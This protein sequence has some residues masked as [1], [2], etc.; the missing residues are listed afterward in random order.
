MEKKSIVREKPRRTAGQRRQ[1]QLLVFVLL[2]LLGVVAFSYYFFWP[3]EETFRLGVFTYAEVE[4]RDFYSW[5]LSQGTLLPRSEYRL[6]APFAGYVQDWQVGIGEMVGSGQVLAVLSSNQLQ[7]D[8]EEA[9][10]D[11]ETG[12]R[13]LKR[14]EMELN[15]EALQNNR[16]MARAKADLVEAQENLELQEELYE[17]E[18]I[19]RRELETARDQLE[20]AEFELEQ[21]HL[22][23][24]IKE[25]QNEARLN[26]VES[27]VVSL[28]EQI[29][30]LEDLLEQGEILAP[31]SGYLASIEVEG[32]RS[33]NQGTFLAKFIGDDGVFYKGEIDVQDSGLVEAGQFALL[34]G[35]T[36]DVPS[37][38]EYVSPLVGDD[39]NTVE[40]ILKP[41]KQD[42]L[43][44]NIKANA[45][46]RVGH[47]PGLLSLPR[48][49]YLVSGERLFVYVIDDDRAYQR[50]VF[51]G[52][53]EGNYIEV[54][55]GLELGE[56]IITSSYEDFKEFKEIEINPE[57]GR[58]R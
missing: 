15:L 55:R 43:R 17:L 13:D 46:I 44:A 32:G 3:E 14:I 18:L 41:E 21:F 51:F 6:E 10:R 1:L 20:R 50:D 56:R 24:E 27:T 47:R 30:V 33:V 37:V 31:A 28:Q 25:L 53:T 23:W 4:N 35:L 8:L 16:E 52:M 54:E 12:L 26:Q 11:L 29:D 34:Q 40:V 5:V 48:G 39:G 58:V 9:R 38:V 42:D 22:R 49:P 19:T 45:S 57:G 36:G 7:E 2:I